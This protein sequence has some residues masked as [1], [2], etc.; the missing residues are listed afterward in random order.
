MSSTNTPQTQ[1]HAENLDMVPLLSFAKSSTIM[2]SPIAFQFY[3]LVI[4]RSAHSPVL[5]W[6]ALLWAFLLSIF[7]GSSH[8]QILNCLN[9]F[10]SGYKTKILFTGDWYESVH[11]AMLS[12]IEQLQEHDYHGVKLKALLENIAMEEQSVGFS[13]PSSCIDCVTR[14]QSLKRWGNPKAHS[15][16]LILD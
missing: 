13:P 3:S 9:E 11:A 6:L 1:G 8:W 15:F 14:L 4:S 16:K 2:E 10:D 12:L 7:F 5:Q